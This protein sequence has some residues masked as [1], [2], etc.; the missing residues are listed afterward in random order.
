MA[1]LR[2]EPSASR[3]QV[4]SSTATPTYSISQHIQIP[5]SKQQLFIN[6]YSTTCF[7]PNGTSSG[8]AS[9]RHSTPEQ[10]RSHSYLYTYG[11]RSYFLYIFSSSTRLD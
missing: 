9:L 10:Q 2:F 5:P 1:Q 4:R 8:A 7:D 11:S 6:I 3:I